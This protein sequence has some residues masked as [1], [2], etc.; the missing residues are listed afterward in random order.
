MCLAVHGRVTEVI[1]ARTRLVA[2]DVAGR[3]EAV[4]LQLLSGPEEP[5]DDWIGSVVA[6]HVGFAVKRLDEADLAALAGLLPM[7]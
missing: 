3:R 7:P 5:L 6:I 1:D 4:S 2:I